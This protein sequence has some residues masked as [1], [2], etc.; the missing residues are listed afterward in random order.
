MSMARKKIAPD[1]PIEVLF[2]VRE[3]EL[4]LAHT[5]AGP[6]LTERLQ[7]AMVAGTKLAV[8]Y[9]LDDLDELLGYIAAEANHTEDERLQGELDA[10]YERLQEAMESYNDGSW[11]EAF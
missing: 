11:H 8:T 5:F 10:L 6:N 9:S 1:S 2:T 7:L 3:R 4:V